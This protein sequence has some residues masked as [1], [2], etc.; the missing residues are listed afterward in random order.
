MGRVNTHTKVD[1]GIYFVL[2]TL[3]LSLGV[4]EKTYA[5]TDPAV[6]T[7]SKADLDPQ[8][9]TIYIA[10]TWKF[11][12]G[13]NT[14][15]AD[16]TLSDSSWQYVSTYLGSSE[17]PFIDWEGIGWFRLH[18]KAD[19]SLIG[20]PLALI[21]EQHNG[22]SEIY[23]DGKLLYALGEV[24]TTVQDYLPYQDRQPRSII[25]EDTT[26]HV[27]SVRFAN[28]DTKTYSDL[29]FTS[30]FRF[31]FGDMNHHVA[32]IIDEDTGYL[33]LRRFFMGLLLAFTI[34]HSLLFGFYPQEKRNLYFALFTGFLTILT[35]TIL[36]TDLSYSPIAA[37]RYYQLSLIVWVLTSVYALR[38]AYS[39]FYKKVP[40]IYWF[41]F[42]TGFTIAIGSWF[43]TQYFSFIRELFVFISVLEIFRILIVSFFRKREGIWLIGSG[44][45][46]FAAGILYTILANLDIVSG[47]PV[48]GNLYGATG[49]ILGM[50]IYLSRE[51]AHI[52]RSLKDKLRE[53]N[54]L[55]EKALEQERIS[56][57]KELERKLLAAENDRKSAELEKARALQLSMLPKKLPECDFWDIDVFMQTAQEVG[58]DF[59]DFVLNT[60]GSK[61]IALGD[62]TGHGMKSGIVVATAKSY[63]HTL[64]GEQNIVNLLRKMSEG[65]KNMDLRMMYMSMLF[66]RF[67]GHHIE[68]TS[69]GMPP[70]LHY[71]AK[72]QAIQVH[73]VKGLPLGGNPDFPYQK[74]TIE[75]Q[76]GDAFLLMSDG[77]MELFNTD[78][79]MLGMSVI[80]SVFK[81]NAHKSVSGILGALKTLADGW[82][83]EDIQQDDITLMVLKAKDTKVRK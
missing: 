18:V 60:D 49:L 24:G 55:S 14:V 7:I 22:A 4:Y 73:L 13:D 59:Y 56:K 29:G 31:F 27:L 9:Q 43:N 44:L 76:P 16:P 2:L 39:L 8:D 47:D 35:Y 77:L 3:T 30:G 1:A 20:Y 42:G 32:K 62:A 69:A 45:I 64:A 34:I 63:F 33:W 81:E 79:E 21:I 6:V 25:F 80:S 50:S 46:L 70:V 75:A 51:F 40:G 26:S 28:F 58:G 17:L 71:K 82:A 36:K 15:W 67:E 54:E 68:Y 65:I 41:F 5:Q 38:F 48:L 57:Q 83:G 66:M 12:P 53:V 37:L 52:N 72:E 19:S 61:T 74:Q 23:W 10:D 11:M 78:R